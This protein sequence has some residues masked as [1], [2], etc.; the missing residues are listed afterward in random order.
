M[1]HMETIEILQKARDHIS[2]TGLHKGWYCDEDGQACCV[3]GAVY[4]AL[5]GDPEPRDHDILSAR[6]A[7]DVLDAAAGEPV[8]D[9]NDDPDTALADV[10][11]LFNRAI[12]N[13]SLDNP[14]QKV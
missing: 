9:F 4:W 12:V 5:F 13:I 8:A 11:Q 3:V 1:T 7:I 2:E 10:I 6:E 14:A